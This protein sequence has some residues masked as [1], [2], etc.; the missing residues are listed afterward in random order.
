MSKTSSA[1]MKAAVRSL[2]RCVTFR[3]IVSV[4]HDELFSAPRTRVRSPYKW[5]PGMRT[6]FQFPIP[7]RMN[8]AFA[9]SRAMVPKLSTSRPSSVP[10]VNAVLHADSVSRSTPLNNRGIASISARLTSVPSPSNKFEFAATPGRESK[11]AAICTT[12]FSRLPHHSLKRSR[13]NSG[14][15]G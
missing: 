10:F 3:F 4:R 1:I 13:V 2:K 6:Y 5:S 12:A 9:P 7:M 14:S 11:C 15:S 8:G